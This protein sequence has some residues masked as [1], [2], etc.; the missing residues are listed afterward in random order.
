MNAEPARRPVRIA[1]CS[2]FYGDRLSAAR[3]MVDGGPIDFLTGDY[4]AE[5]TMLIL[6]KSRAKGGKGYAR[7]FLGQMHD[8]LKDCA[9]RNIKVVTNAG[10]LDPA[11]LAEDLRKLA[12]TLHVDV[13]IAHVEGD[14]ILARL[15]EIRAAGQD[16][17]HLDTGR[18]FEESMEPVSANAYLGAWGIVAALAAGADIVVCGRVTDAS[19]VVGPAAWWHG[20]RP[21][22]WDALAGAVAA[23]H[24]IECGPQATGGNYSFL[25]E[26]PDARPPG[27]PIAEVAAD[28]SA[29]ITK[30]RGTGGAVTVGT[31]TAQLLYEIGPPAYVN[32]D[33]TAHFDTLRL[34]RTGPD[35][36]LISGT[37]GTTG[38]HTLKVCLNYRGGYRNSVTLGITGLDIEEKAA[39]VEAQLFQILGGKA[40]F[41]EVHV[42]LQ[43][44]DQPAAKARTSEEATAYL[45][46]TVKDRDP[47]MVGRE[48]TAAVIELAVAS[49]AG[50]HPTS[51]AGRASE[52][53]VYWP[54]LIQ[55]R[56]VTH[57]AV[58]TDG[59]R[60][61]IESFREPMGLPLHAVVSDEPAR[62]TAD[63][64]GTRRGALGTVCGARSGDKGGNA[65][66]GVWTRDDRSYAWLREYLTA[67]GLKELI[68][69]AADLDVRRYALPNVRALNFVLVGLLG[70]G[71]AS[72]ARAD[73]QAKGLGE[74]LRSRQV[75]L[76]VEFL[77][78]EPR[79]NP[80]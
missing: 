6:H 24:V 66:V 41:A 65:N 21:R 13:K 32:P 31:V 47:D 10:G 69:E 35:R 62:F 78:R 38:P 70:E 39:R 37:R 44:S 4:L 7:S 79:L 5:L 9:E 23:G 30:H 56:H 40:R 1:N 80:G 49:Y 60:V 43:R 17:A 45:H 20:W 50:F 58:L 28:G 75:D 11:G 59:R 27:F 14:D 67:E 53:G 3:E 29:T 36:V 8:V 72:S 76:P 57:S 18:P 2:G 15:G 61:V 51:S 64:S 12:E 73:P 25:D 26:I 55:D 63:G 34:T 52:Y 74:F 16:L 46:I 42:R 68:P 54:T 48:F 33:V 77:N 71:V 19:L 22:D